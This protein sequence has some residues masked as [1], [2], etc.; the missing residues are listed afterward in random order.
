M[1]GRRGTLASIGSPL[2]RKDCQPI[3]GVDDSPI[4]HSPDY[5]ESVRIVP[6]CRSI[7][8][9]WRAPAGRLSFGISGSAMVGSPMML[10]YP[11]DRAEAGLLRQWR[12]NGPRGAADSTACN[13]GCATQELW[14]TQASSDRPALLMAWQVLLWYVPLPIDTPRK[15]EHE[16][17]RTFHALQARIRQAC[18]R[19]LPAGRR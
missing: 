6:G 8:A 5:A 2:S 13:A 1:S 16:R 7:S 3:H 17:R 12:R 15:I 4:G 14:E 11:G 19:L 18:P 10:R 9:G